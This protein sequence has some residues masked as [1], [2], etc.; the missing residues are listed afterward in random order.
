MNEIV[1]FLIN[2][3]VALVVFVFVL[4]LSIRKRPEKP[5]LK[6]ILLSAIAVIGGMIFAKIAF[7][8]GISWWIFYGVPAFVT[9]V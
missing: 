5:M 9:F 3:L 4:S 6:I 8:K 2:M 1:K 7:G